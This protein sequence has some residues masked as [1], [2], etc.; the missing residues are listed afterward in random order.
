MQRLLL[1][2][3]L[4]VSSLLAQRPDCA[5]KGVVTAPAHD[6]KAIVHALEGKKKKP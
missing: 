5:L 2:L 6:A 4:L 3:A 1:S